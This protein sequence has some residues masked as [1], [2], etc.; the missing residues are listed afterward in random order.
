[1]SIHNA[2]RSGLTALAVV[3]A[4]LGCNP[5]IPIPGRSG[6]R[7]AGAADSHAVLTV[8]PPA[9]LDGLP[10]VVRLHVTT[11]SSAGT[12]VTPEGLALVRGAIGRAHLRQ[13]QRGEVSASLAKRLVPALVFPDEPAEDA[14]LTPAGVTLVPTVPLAAGE[15][16]ALAVAATGEIIPL[17]TGT[18]DT[19]PLL[20]RV[21]PPLGASASDSFGVWCGA[22]PLAEGLTP[23]DLAPSHR[24]GE[25]RRGLAEG[26]PGARCLRFQAAPLPANTVGVPPP[27]IAAGRL[28]P[29]P[30]TIDGPLEPIDPLSCLPDE[31]PFG[32]GCARLL[33][34][35]LL[36]R[37]PEARALWSIQGEGIDQVFATA[38]RTPF[39]IAPLSPNTPI[40]LQLTTIGNDGSAQNAVFS[41]I[42][43][44]PQAH[45]VINEVLANPIGAE[46]TQEWIELVNDGLIAVD[47][48]GYTLVDLLGETALPSFILAP[49]SFALIVNQDFVEDDEVDALP[50]PGTPLIRV[51][52]LGRSGLSNAGEPLKLLGPDGTVLSR[53]PALPHSRAGMSIAR[54]T[55]STPDALRDGFF[56]ARP[57]PGRPNGP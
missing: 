18:H 54:R 12:P 24:D 30:L 50:A 2:R 9:P 33:D 37:G 15:L 11:S 7:A 23:I 5:Q 51:P 42:T 39:V 29:R 31:V 20:E 22:T 17:R 16:Y 1:M 6:P 55:P 34:D 56:V 49:G 19:I 48:G 8:E 10:P 53:F 13:I 43:P 40:S 57:T 35:R 4:L 46:P 44:L 27:L 38:A 45:T 25:L 26:D 3:V 52:E 41:A 28:D 14:A 21:W 36:A 32:P 47:L